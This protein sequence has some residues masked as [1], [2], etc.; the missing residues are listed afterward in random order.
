M[1]PDGL[2]KQLTAQYKMPGNV[3]VKNTR[4]NP[5][6]WSEMSAIDKRKD[7]GCVPGMYRIRQ[8]YVYVV[9]YTAAVFY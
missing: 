3:K 6:I 9:F 4:V 8:T 1:L 5:E 2:F 7:T